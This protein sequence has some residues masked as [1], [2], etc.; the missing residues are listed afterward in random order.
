[1]ASAGTVTLN[2]DANSVKLLRELQKSQRATQRTASKM[3]K[4]MTRAFATIRTVVLSASTAM[5]AFGAFRGFTRIAGEIDQIGKM[6]DRLGGSTEAFSELQ[7]VAERSGLAF[8]T[9][10]MGLQR[11]Q[12]RVAEAAGGFGEA[13]GA[14]KELGLSAAAL[15]SLSL[16]QQFEVIADALFKVTTEGDR[17]RLAMKLF[18]SEGVA[19]LQ[20]MKNGAGGIRE[21]REE[22]KR[23]GVSLNRDQVAAATAANDAMTDLRASASALGR[24]LAVELAPSIA[25]ITEGL[26]NMLSGNR[27]AEIARRMDTIRK[28]L[29][30]AGHDPKIAKVLLDEFAALAK[31]LESLKNPVYTAADA[32]E[33]LQEIVVTVSKKTDIYAEDL[34]SFS[35]GFQT[36]KM[37]ADALRRALVRFQKDLDPSQIKLVQEAIED[38]RVGGIEEIDLSSLPKLKTTSKQTFEDISEYAKQAA[39]NTQDAFA[40]F[41]FDPFDEGLKGMLKSFLDTMRRMAAN[42]L[43]SSI[44]DFTGLT[45]IFG[46]GRQFGGPVSAGVPYMVGEAGP[47]LFVPNSSGSVVANNKLGSTSII[48]NFQA[49][50]DVATIRAEIIPM[51]ERTQQASVAEIHR[52]RREGIL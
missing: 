28:D 32:L 40:D 1:M 19:L 2:L 8:N 4:S 26:N 20:T 9:L 45:K 21:L 11:M 48:Y 50:A 39:R 42:Q 3:Q 37:R 35:S 24:T 5:A 47:E 17:T 7:F 43:A 30:F 33:E 15:N 6:V 16:D 52:Q 25:R 18:D 41:L 44:F 51:L 22:A 36:A 34:K 38:I 27:Q 13:K 31:E 29:D 12:R 49:G 10:T 23:L 14:L 46:G